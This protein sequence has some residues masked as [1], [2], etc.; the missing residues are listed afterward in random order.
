MKANAMIVRFLAPALLLLPAC[1]FAGDA[2]APK[3]MR[4]G[5]VTLTRT[6]PGLRDPWSLAVLPDGRM[7]VSE[8]YDGLALLEADGRTVR[9]LVGV[10]GDA[11]KSGQSGY[12][13]VV[14]D[15][16]FASNRSFYL[17]FLQGTKKAN[18]LAVWKAQLGEKGVEAG[19]IIFH[20]A[21]VRK[22]DL[23]PGGR[24][25]FLP[26]KTLLLSVGDGFA[27]REKAQDLTSHLGKIL[28]ID[29]D[30][31]APADNPFVG[32]TGA[33]PEIYS[34]GHRNPQG[35]T[36]DAASNTVWAHEHGPM[37]GDEVNRI[38]P[39]T[40]YG[41][42]RVSHGVNYDG[43]A[44]S[45]RKTAPGYAE[46]QH[47]WVPS[48]A[49]SGLALVRAGGPKAWEGQLLAGALAGRMLVRLSW[50]AA[51]GEWREEERMFTDLE[52]RIRD[53]RQ[54]PDGSIL[55]LTDGSG[56]LWRLR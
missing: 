51:S 31:Q 30:G 13:D 33:K 35:L 38:T 20:V 47:I 39:G 32:K 24:M 29:R 42:P 52:E 28:R 55:I 50:D 16:D 54:A 17:A 40:N 27:Y 45:D 4:V 36:Y 21:D 22:G 25:A 11:V 18:G 10:P 44:V 46:A 23:H 9:R 41:W 15:P 2:Q 14:L 48:I 12:L 26:D 49:P 8:K 53:V 19:R 43:T 3:E 7:L 37:G 1:S 6:T 5:D 56:E 34:L